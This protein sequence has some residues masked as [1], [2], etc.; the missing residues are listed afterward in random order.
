MHTNVALL[1]GRLATD[2]QLRRR[3]ADDPMG[4]LSSLVERG[5]EL[6]T[7]EIDALAS[8]DPEAIKTFASALDRRLRHAVTTTTQ[9][10][11]R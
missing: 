11:N 3:F 4:L 9:G 2:S 5:F 6:T 7:V 1:L 10:D 8:L